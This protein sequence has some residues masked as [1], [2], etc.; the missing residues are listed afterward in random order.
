MVGADDEIMEVISR[1]YFAIPFL[2][3]VAILFL[4]V[5]IASRV[6]LVDYPGGHKKHTKPTA[7]VGGVAIYLGFFLSVIFLNI[8]L[9]DVSP[10]LVACLLLAMIG[11][12][13]DLFQFSSS[14]RFAAQIIACLVMIYWGG[15]QLFTLGDLLGN[16]SIVLGVL[17]IPLTI[18]STVG[19]INAFNMIDGMD[20]LSSSLMLV[21]FASLFWIAI[22]AGRSDQAELL[23]IVEM[24]VFAFFLFN[25]RLGLRVK[26]AV[27]LGDSGSMFLGFL[28]AWFLIKFT[29]TS[30]AIM[31]P[32]TAL[33]IIAIP[34]SDTVG[35]MLRR[36][37]GG[38]SPFAADRTHI[39]HLLQHAGFGVN[40]S[41]ICLVLVALIMAGIGVFGDLNGIDSPILFSGFMLFF[42]VQFITTTY[43]VRKHR[44]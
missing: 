38:C 18:F 11:L 30:D 23:V 40:Q 27:F 25:A 8:S 9:L 10:M 5:Q 12:L 16:G 15:V 36:I 21:A 32:V 35:V 37:I 17:A 3:T 28:L 44:L 19:V 22:G 31:A 13:D 1:F 29:Q 26:A 43:Y 4:L 33:W 24:G 20:G 14:T 41:L 39:H 2:L 6:G 7:V 34:L 42:S